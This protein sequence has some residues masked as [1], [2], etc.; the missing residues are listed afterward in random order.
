[1]RG[2]DSEGQRAQR[3][4]SIEFVGE[5]STRYKL[6]NLPPHTIFALY[7]DFG[8]VRPVAVPLTPRWGGDFLYY[9]AF[10]RAEIVIFSNRNRSDNLKY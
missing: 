3:S 5:G 1:M 6:C 10:D 2:S 4:A 9:A 7:P 8:A